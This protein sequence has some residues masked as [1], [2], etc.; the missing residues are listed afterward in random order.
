[1]EEFG[2]RVD[3][4]FVDCKQLSWRADEDTD[5]FRSIDLQHVSMQLM[6][7][8]NLKLSLPQRKDE[9]LTFLESEGM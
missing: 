5:E 3:E 9:D 2:C 6:F 7:V 4:V 8:A 1:L